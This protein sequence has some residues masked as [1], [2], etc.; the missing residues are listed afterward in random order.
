VAGANRLLADFAGFDEELLPGELA[1][2]FAGFDDHAPDEL[3]AGFDRFDKDG[4]SSLSTAEAPSPMPQ[5]GTAVPAGPVSQLLEQLPKEERDEV[6]GFAQA[7]GATVTHVISRR[8]PDPVFPHEA[9]H[10]WETWCKK[11]N[12]RIFAR[13]REAGGP[14]NLYDQLQEADEEKKRERQQRKD[15]LDR[16]RRIAHHW[17]RWMRWHS[18]DSQAAE[19]YRTQHQDTEGCDE[20][21]L[22]FG[23]V[24]LP[25]RQGTNSQGRK[26]ETVGQT[27]E[28]E[29]NQSRRVL[30]LFDLDDE[31]NTFDLLREHIS[32]ELCT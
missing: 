31:Q 4:P 8:A 30:Q 11:R 12:Q 10:D 28:K 16:Q 23:P 9:T 6:M 15:W 13:A 21:W 5:S 22:E 29:Q 14:K 1:A 3:R 20:K 25:R 17:A 7:L 2:E 19:T 26:I 32:S 18:V 24:R 27:C